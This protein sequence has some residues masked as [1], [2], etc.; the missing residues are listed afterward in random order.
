MGAALDAV[1]ADIREHRI[2]GG[3]GGFFTA[4]RHIEL[5]GHLAIR[6]AGDAHHHLNEGQ[7]TSSARHPAET[8]SQT[9]GHIGHAVAHYT[10]ALTPLAALAQP[11]APTTLDW[12]LDAIDRHRDLHAHLSH[13][14]Q[15][16]DEA[17]ASLTSLNPALESKGSPPPSPT[18][19]ARTTPRP[20]RR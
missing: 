7:Q 4:L 11:G 19:A 16:L 10:L 18:T 17:R 20:P 9:A 12:Q 1:I 3:P 15:A 2:A 6:L 5:L 13:A 14:H 8:L